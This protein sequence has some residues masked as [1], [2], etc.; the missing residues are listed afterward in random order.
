MIPTND[1][2]AC[3]FVS[4]PPERFVAERG[5]GLGRLFLDVLHEVSPELHVRA[6]S[7]DLPKVRGFAGAPSMLRRS[8]GPGWALVGDAGY[9]KDPLTAHGMTDALRDAELLARAIVAGREGGD[10]MD[11]A[12]ASYEETRNRLSVGLLDVTSRIASL[13]WTLDEAKQLH[14]ALSREMK[15]EVESMRAWDRVRPAA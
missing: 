6:T 9:F 11:D 3:V 15:A 10:V 14:R 1:E 8:A 12:L 4:L 7:G 2:R 13:A 5:R